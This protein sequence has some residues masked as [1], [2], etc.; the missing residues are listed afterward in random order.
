M[1]LID[2]AR[3]LWK[4]SRNNIQFRTEQKHK[5]GNCF[6]PPANIVFLLHSLPHCLHWVPFLALPPSFSWKCFSF[7][8]RVLSMPTMDFHHR[9]Q[10]TNPWRFDQKRFT[11]FKNMWAVSKMSTLIVY[12]RCVFLTNTNFFWSLWIVFDQTFKDWS[13]GIY[14]ENPWWA[15]TR[16]NT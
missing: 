4:L 5:S 3:K 13:P 2:L 11:N 15:W 9:Y 6:M 8:C 12:K 14:D 7:M 1:N 16:L 10:E